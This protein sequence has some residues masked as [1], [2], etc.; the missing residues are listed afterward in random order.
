MLCVLTILALALVLIV[1]YKPPWSNG[2]R[3]RGVAAELA[4]GLRLARSEAIVLNRPSAFELDL[5]A[6]RYRIGSGSPHQL[7]AQLNITLLTI[8]GERR[9]EKTGIIRFNPDGSTGGGRISIDNGAQR[10]DIGI[11]WLNGRVTI[12]DAH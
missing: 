3:L 12:A 6:H 11:D 8:A 10:I 2:L 5:A 9:D 1:G 4:G 7:P